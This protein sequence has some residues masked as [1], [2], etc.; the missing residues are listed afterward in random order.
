MRVSIVSGETPNPRRQNRSA[1]RRVSSRSAWLIPRCRWQAAHTT[2]YS[3]FAAG[4]DPGNPV[5]RAITA[6]MRA[7]FP[8]HGIDLS[9]LG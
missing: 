2:P 5:D 3:D 6:T 7:V 9:D 4:H 8:S 1:R